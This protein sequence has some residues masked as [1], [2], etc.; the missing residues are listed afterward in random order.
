MIESFIG[1]PTTLDWIGMVITFTVTSLIVVIIELLRRKF[2]IRE[3]ISRK[4]IHIC[5]GNI[6]FLTP[7]LFDHGIYAGL[8]P[9]LFIPLNWLTGPLSPIEKMRLGS[10]EEGQKLGTIF[11]AISLTWIVLVFHMYPLVLYL[12]FLPLVWYDGIA[13]FIG[14]KFVPDEKKMTIFGNQKSWLGILSGFIASFVILIISGLI[15]HFTIYELKI[16]VIFFLAGT[17]SLIAA[18]FETFSIKGTDNLF[19]PAACSVFTFL[20]VHFTSLA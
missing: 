11:Y 4:L 7:F 6:I 2:E 3:V 14:I 18:L 20:I 19:I 13:A 1:A 5:V 10:Y 8:I 15:V 12:G 9:A 17:V 16:W